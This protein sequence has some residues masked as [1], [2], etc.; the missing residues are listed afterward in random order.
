MKGRSLAAF[1]K[2][3]PK[4]RTGI[5]CPACMTLS[6]KLDR[7]VRAAY[8]SGQFTA[9]EIHDWLT[10]KGKKIPSPYSLR[11]HIRLHPPVGRK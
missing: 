2:A 4:N 1:V 7:E 3:R 5:P 9:V 11:W 10:S 6:P 8:M